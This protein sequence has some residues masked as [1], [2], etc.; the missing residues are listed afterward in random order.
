MDWREA[1]FAVLAAVYLCVY[2]WWGAG[3]GE[4]GV[5]CVWVEVPMKQSRAVLSRAAR[6]LNRSA[7]SDS[8]RRHGL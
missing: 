1:G 8:F 3:S 5:G 2:V 4:L 7:V 6:M